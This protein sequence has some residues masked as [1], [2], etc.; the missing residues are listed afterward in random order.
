MEIINRKARYEYTILEKFVA[1]I[2][3]QGSEVKS[4]REGKCNISDAYCYI[5]N[6]EIFLKNAHISKYESDTFTNHDELRDKKLLLTKKEIR[7]LDIKNSAPGTTIV[8]LCI[9]IHKN[10]LVKVEVA[11]CK[12]RKEFDKR[13]AIK[14]KDIQRE[15]ERSL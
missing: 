3:L 2:V 15:I 1:G 4:I 12:G 8:P 14:E 9:F 5:H 6:N 7:K 11:L 13:E 10:G